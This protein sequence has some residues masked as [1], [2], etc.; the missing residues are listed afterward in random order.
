MRWLGYLAAALGL[1]CGAAAHELDHFNLPSGTRFADLGP[2]LTERAYEHITTAVAKLNARL[3]R[4]SKAE[5]ERLSSPDALAE[6]VC[7][8]FPPV[9]DYIQ[10]LERLFH[11]PAFTRRYAGLIV[12]HLP[13]PWIYD[14]AQTPLEP[15]AF[16]LL[17]R[18]SLVRVNGVFVGTDK[19]GHFV[20][21]GYNY[22]TIYRDTLRSGADEATAWRTAVRAGVD[23]NF[24]ISE[25]GL[26]GVLTSSVISNADLAANYLGFLFYL[27]LSREVMLRGAPQPPLATFDGRWR[28]APHVRPDGDFFVRFFCEQMDEVLNP[29]IYEPRMHEIVL[30]RIH[31]Q[32]ARIRAWYADANGVPRTRAWFAAK[33]EELKT[34]FGQD[35]GYIA[36]SPAG[37]IRMEDLCWTDGADDGGPIPGEAVDPLGRTALL[38][39][40][41]AGGAAEVSAALAGADVNQADL[42]GETALHHAARRGDSEIVRRL[43]AAGARVDARDRYQC[44]PL[45]VAAGAAGAEVVAALLDAGAPAAAAD[46]F[47][48]TALHAAAEAGRGE[49]AS[50]LLERGAPVGAQ[51]AGGNTPLH[52]AARAGRGEAAQR[53]LA[54]GADRCATNR[55][56]RT[57]AQEARLAGHA[58]LSE[59]LGRPGGEPAATAGTLEK[60]P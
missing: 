14:G 59:I 51:D 22:Y 53:L 56:L 57:P 1:V 52:C 39:A 31:A 20:H 5:R 28:V 36:E 4:A 21:N 34:Y 30:P 12:A 45:H 40:V 24:F 58:R 26:L 35:Y 8:E 25:R 7:A 44:T 29:S 3:E 38:R 55:L 54:A 2:H 15:R 32:C 13:S 41:R 33:T 43:L 49:C 9:V 47:G 16:F 19:I 60:R 18:S 17:W 37:F 27:N 10:G 23:G 6:A 46:L 48:A 11:D 42:D 50:R